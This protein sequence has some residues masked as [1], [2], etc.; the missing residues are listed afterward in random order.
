MVRV[1]P[2]SAESVERAKLFIAF[3]RFI[4]FAPSYPPLM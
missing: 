3:V 4:F 1:E 2:I